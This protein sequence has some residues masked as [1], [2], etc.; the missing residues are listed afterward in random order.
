S[1][2]YDL[3]CA[4]AGL[5]ALGHPARLAAWD[6]DFRSAAAPAKAALTVPI[7]GANYVKPRTPRPPA[8]RRDGGNTSAPPPPPPAPPP[9]APE[10]TRMPAP[11]PAPHGKSS[12]TMNGHS[13][14]REPAPT[15][16]AAP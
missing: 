1:G 14:A 9:R 7:C 13:P 5:A 16:P 3:A 8:P 11:R 12:P 4:L 10:P 15:P 2:V 6:G